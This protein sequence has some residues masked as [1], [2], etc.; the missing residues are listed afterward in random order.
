M[1]AEWA[2]RLA[3]SGFRDIEGPNGVLVDHGAPMAPSEL[4]LGASERA[5]E[6]LSLPAIWQGLS[7]EHKR[8]W[9]LVAIAG[10]DAETAGR[11]LGIS[12]R[13][14]HAIHR[15]VLGRVECYQ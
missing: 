8:L 10:W 13:R 6:A 1:T 4:A 3:E 5:V 12:R 15:T 11:L 2:R 7:A 14:A 9:V